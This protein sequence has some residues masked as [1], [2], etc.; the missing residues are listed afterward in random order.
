MRIGALILL[1]IFRSV[2]IL[3]L[4]VQLPWAAQVVQQLHALVMQYPVV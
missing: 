2:V 1:A 3:M 4:M